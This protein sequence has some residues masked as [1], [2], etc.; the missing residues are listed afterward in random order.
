MSFLK[1]KVFIAVLLIGCAMGCKT[2][3]VSARAADDKYPTSASD[4][5]MALQNAIR[6]GDRNSVVAMTRFPVQLGEAG[7]MLDRPALT[8]V[9]EKVWTIKAANAVLNQAPDQLSRG[10]HVFVGCGEVWFEK[11][12]DQQFRIST[13]DV[14][15]YSAAAI[16]VE[17]CYRARDFVT[18]LKGE[19]AADH[20]KQ[21]ADMLKYPLYFHGLHKNV[22]LRS[23][24]Q[25]LRNYDLVFSDRLRHA[26]AEQQ[27]WNLL[28][29]AEG[30][31]IGD[32]FI[33]INQPAA[34][35]PFKMVSIFEP[36]QGR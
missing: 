15:A 20:R 5:L 4:F 12:K 21:V 1:V 13:F 35:G 24:E 3:H 29:Q 7:T 36:P 11:T 19:I 34:G 28:S 23:P 30:V 14:S 33:W 2:E 31:A 25:L 22:E 17:D 32:G 18:Q 8:N 6:R 27:V 9:Y 10:R 16:S 26:V